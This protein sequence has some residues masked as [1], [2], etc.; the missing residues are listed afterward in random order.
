MS[1]LISTDY[2]YAHSYKKN[3]LNQH[4]PLSKR[5]R[6]TVFVNGDEHYAAEYGSFLLTIVIATIGYVINK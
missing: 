3:L 6:F 2:W 5:S 4:V 1:A